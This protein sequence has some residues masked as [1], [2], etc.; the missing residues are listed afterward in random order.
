MTVDNWSLL[1]YELMCIYEYYVQNKIQRTVP[2]WGR[3]TSNFYW[4]PA[5]LGLKAASGII[6]P[7][8]L[9]LSNKVLYLERSVGRD[10]LMCQ[11]EQL[12]IER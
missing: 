5:L 7:Q 4:P 1:C 10:L 11:A 12:S 2:M 8:S 6:N 9:N 3:E